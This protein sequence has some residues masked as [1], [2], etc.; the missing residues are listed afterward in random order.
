MGSLKQSG[1]KKVNE[2]TIKQLVDQGN[3]TA[4]LLGNIMG[5]I[6]VLW[7]DIEKGIHT[8]LEDVANVLS[9]IHELASVK[10]QDIYYKHLQDDVEHE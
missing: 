10:I 2:V 5:G 8:D 3:R 6:A 9:K 4:L 1:A 7:S